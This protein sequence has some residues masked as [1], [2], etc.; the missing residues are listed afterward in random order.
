MT[1]RASNSLAWSTRSNNMNSVIW[2]QDA[3]LLNLALGHPLWQS[4]PWNCQHQA[5]CYLRSNSV[6]RVSVFQCRHRMT[7]A[8]RLDHRCWTC[9]NLLTLQQQTDFVGHCCGVAC[10]HLC[11]HLRGQ[12][13]RQ[14]HL[15]VW[16]DWLS[17]SRL[18]C[19]PAVSGLHAPPT[20]SGVLLASAAT[21]AAKL[22]SSSTS[23]CCRWSA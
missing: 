15:L 17:T 1:G 6:S 19:Q 8:C 10:A 14:Q 23:N 18:Q 9:S 22:Q 3:H 11:L 16:Q 20:S 7:S 12:A 13:G 5:A 4:D 2:S 21:C